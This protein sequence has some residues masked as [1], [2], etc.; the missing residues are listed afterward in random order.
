MSEKVVIERPIGC[1]VYSEASQTQD[2]R[3]A[4]VTQNEQGKYRELFQPILCR[5]YF[6]DALHGQYFK[7][8]KVEMYGFAW[9]SAQQQYNPDQLQMSVTFGNKVLEETTMRQLAQ[10]LMSIEEANG[11]AKTYIQPS[12]ID[13]KWLFLGDACWQRNSFLIGL[14]T[15]LIRVASISFKDASKWHEELAQ[16]SA[17]YSDRSFVVDTNGRLMASLPRLRAIVEAHDASPDVSPTGWTVKSSTWNVHNRSGCI[18]HLFP[19]Y[20]A[21]NPLTKLINEV[22]DKKAA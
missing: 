13:R 14:Y 19:D 22:I 21:D 8:A 15:Y 4:F 20:G 9:E 1:F 11:W 17:H 10:I 6:S 18:S 2:V 16:S 7:L 3:F 12:T 5:D